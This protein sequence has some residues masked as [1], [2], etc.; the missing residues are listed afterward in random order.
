MGAIVREQMIVAKN[1]GHFGKPI[2]LRM[3]LRR[4][5]NLRTETERLN[6]PILTNGL[7]I[8]EFISSD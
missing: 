5:A 7:G 3:G 6:S 4:L 1:I 8:L 2:A